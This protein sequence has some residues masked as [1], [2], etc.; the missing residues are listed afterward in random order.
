MPC[1]A[2]LIDFGSLSRSVGL[3]A[4]FSCLALLSIFVHIQDSWSTEAMLEEL[5]SCSILQ[6]CNAVSLEVVYLMLQAFCL[7][8]LQMFL[9][10]PTE[11]DERNFTAFPS[12]CSKLV[13]SLHSFPTHM[14]RL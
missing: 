8:K 10:R 1:L 7:P 2:G 6:L 12:F 5:V 13:S 9:F 3:L 11:L 14:F 4:S